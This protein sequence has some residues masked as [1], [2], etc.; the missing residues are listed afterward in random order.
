MVRHSGSTI[1]ILL[2][3]AQTV[4]ALGTDDQEKVRVHFAVLP[5]SSQT[6]QQTLYYTQEGEPEVS[7]AMELSLNPRERS[8]YFFYNGINP[9][10]VFI[11]EEN[12][13]GVTVLSPVYQVDFANSGGRWL[14]MLEAPPEDPL[15]RPYG[16]H[17]MP[18]DESRFPEGSL[19]FF[20]TTG[21]N[22]YGILGENQVTIQPG[23]NQPIDIR[24]YYEDEIAVGLVV[25]DGDQ[26]H[27]VLVSK[28][29]F[30][31]DRR[32][33]M[34]LRPPKR[35]G[36]YRIQAQRITEYLGKFDSNDSGA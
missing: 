18:Y 28:M 26:I 9:M 19:L 3:L 7:D 1:T 22:F 25:K 21:A 11:K 29:S 36:S 31:P 6:A 15:L 12:E 23:A 5:L 4:F 2:I 10:P 8:D 20:N 35:S 17:C 24:E 32:T 13:D 33:L 30:Y 34:I 27:K 16:S 14:I